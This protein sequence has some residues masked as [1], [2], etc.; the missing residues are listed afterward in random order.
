MILAD[1]VPGTVTEAVAVVVFIAPGA[2]WLFLH[3][4]RRPSAN[5]RTSTDLGYVLF[6]GLVAS[7]L[8]AAFCAGALRVV[9]PASFERLHTLIVDDGS[10]TRF[11][12]GLPLGFGVAVLLGALGLVVASFGIERIARTLYGPR[13]H[14]GSALAQLIEAAAPHDELIVALADD[15]PVIVGRPWIE[16]RT[17]LV[18]RAPIRR[19][20]PDH[21]SFRASP[22]RSVVIPLDRIA[23]VGL[24]GPERPTSPGPSPGRGAGR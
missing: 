16:D 4:K 23:T 18:L 5:L 14:P 11:G 13:L 9:G 8:S 6:V 17:H 15:G 21:Q 7:A 24:V 2:L 22:E 10:A 12:L 3:A 20:T 1:I 19:R